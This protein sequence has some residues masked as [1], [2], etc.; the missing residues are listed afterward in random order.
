VLSNCGAANEFQSAVESVAT[1]TATPEFLYW[2]TNAHGSV[3][4]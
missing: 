3:P 1:L 2:V 4:W